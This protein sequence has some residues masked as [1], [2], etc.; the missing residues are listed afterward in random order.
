MKFKDPVDRLRRLRMI[1][2]GLIGG[3]GTMLAVLPAA[4]SAA[5]ALPSPH[6]FVYRVTSQNSSSSLYLYG[7][8]H[9]GRVNGAGLDGPT[10]ALIAGCR[11]VALELDPRNSA[12]LSAALKKYALYPPEDRLGLHI[13]ADL[14][15]RALSEAEAVHM[16]RARAEQIKPWMLAN[17][18]SVLN[19]SRNGY[20][21][22]RSSESLLVAEAEK[23][24]ADVIEIE[25]ADVQMKLL[26]DAPG[27]VQVDALEKTVEQIGDGHIGDEA[28]ALLDA[29]DQSDAKAI[30]KILADLTAEPGPYPKFMAEQ[31]LGSRNQSMADAAEKQIAAPG[32]TLFAVGTLHLLG[33]KG[34][35]AELRRRG[36]AVTALSVS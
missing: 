30:D 2:R 7:T 23:A 17:F 36:Y 10:I 20:D 26:G 27:D 14:D 12:A 34:L 33:P 11:H 1:W 21:P 8:L 18:L 19:L 28:K 3:C 35:V 29:W 5:P 15:R 25:G 9:V 24:H 31:V 4:F 32:N 13:P 22:R 6:G 16:P